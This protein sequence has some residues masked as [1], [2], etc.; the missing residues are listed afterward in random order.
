MP[1]LLWRSRS[2]LRA[3]HQF[4]TLW[5]PL[6]EALFLKLRQ[7]APPAQAYRAFKLPKS[8]LVMI[9]ALLPA[10]IQVAHRISPS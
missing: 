9:E 3:W 6:D 8:F 4:K 5:I 7:R 1:C 10:N 2:G